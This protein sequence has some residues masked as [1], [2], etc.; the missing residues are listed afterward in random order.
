ML[1]NSNEPE[2][3]KTLSFACG[4]IFRYELQFEHLFVIKSKQQVQY[5]VSRTNFHHKI[6]SKVK[7]FM[8]AIF[9]EQVFVWLKNA[10]QVPTVDYTNSCPEPIWSNMDL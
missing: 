6:F 1:K 5:L 3:Q 10:L 7:T 8:K 4:T 9:L 2:R